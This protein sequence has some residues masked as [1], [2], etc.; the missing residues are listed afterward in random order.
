[1]TNSTNRR[2]ANRG[3]TSTVDPPITLNSDDSR[4]KR[5]ASLAVGQTESLVSRIDFDSATRDS[6][7]E[8]RLTNRKKLDV[9]VRRVSEGTD[10]TFVVEAGQ[11][12]TRSG[13]L[14]VITAATRTR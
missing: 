2:M 8:L 5:L 4:P 6:I 9:A 10:K 14:L 12:I 11:I 7:K 1:M 13:D 3:S